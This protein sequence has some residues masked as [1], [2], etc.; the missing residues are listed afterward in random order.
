M[1]CW[2]NTETITLSL[3]KARIS[4]FTRNHS[5]LNQCKCIVRA[6]WQYVS[7]RTWSPRSLSPLVSF[8]SNVAS[9]KA[10]L[11]LWCWV[12]HCCCTATT[13]HY[14]TLLSQHSQQ[15]LAKQTTLQYSKTT[16]SKEGLI[17][18]Y[19]FRSYCVVDIVSTKSCSSHACSNSLPA[20]AALL[21]R[22]YLEQVE[23]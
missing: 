4:F 19:S 6:I 5:K 20:P 12:L 3:G 23:E 10:E 9:V 7:C 15:Y 16:V 1:L 2:V 17:W 22:L 18:P 11:S 13:C 8:V 21:L 14:C